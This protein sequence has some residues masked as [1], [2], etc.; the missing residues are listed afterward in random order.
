MVVVAVSVDKNDDRYKKFLSRIPVVFQTTRD[1]NADISAA[2]GT[3]VFPETY[4]IKDGRVVRKFAEA[5]NWMS[6]DMTQYV[7]S[8]L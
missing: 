1:P 4:I 2:Y 6:D 8:L 3:N 7:R 5:E